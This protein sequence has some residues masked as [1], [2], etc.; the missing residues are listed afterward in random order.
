MPQKPTK[1]QP[2]SRGTGG[3]FSGSRD[4][5][6]GGKKGG[7]SKRSE[8]DKPKRSYSRDSEDR[9]S[10]GGYDR[11][12]A[13]KSFGDKKYGDRKPAGK[14]FGGDRKYGEKKEYGDRKPSGKSFG[15][16]KYGEKKEYGD[17]KPAGRGFGDKKFGDRKFGDKKEYGDRK[18]S[19]KSF[20]DRKY[21]DKK[22][23]GDRKPA[24]RGFGD[25]K[26]GDRK[27]G[28]RDR[29][30]GDRKFGPKKFGD[31]GQST[32][33]DRQK[34]WSR[35]EEPQRERRVAS[36]ETKG[37]LK[38][39]RSSYGSPS[40]NF[41]FGVHAVSQAL[42]NPQR[43][44]N[45]LLATEKGFAAIEES[46]NEARDEGLTVPEVTYVESEDIDRLTPRE[47]V[48]QDVLLDTAPLE[49]VFL[50][51]VLLHAKDDAFVVVL[52]QVTDP[53]NV[54]AILRSAAAF[55]AVAVIAQKLHAPEITGTLAKTASGAAEHVPLV[56]EVNLSRTLEQLKDAGFA[57]IGLDERGER[58]LAK[59]APKGKVAIVLGN[60]GDGLRRLV[61]ENCDFLAQLPTQG[62][63]ASLNVSNAAAIA[64]YELV[65][66]R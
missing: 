44:H 34:T 43:H 59:A 17:R 63:I 42:L 23:Y 58:T 3:K 39:G 20:G 24:G 1:F 61:A 8:G 55:G 50:Q 52:D 62:E 51:D 49:E 41:L 9:G 32:G 2:K 54:G 7:F 13:G 38:S 46:Y 65:R 28:D 64:L 60:E 30:S 31:R 29:D 6:S 45:R 15:D 36:D 33:F 37:K 4:G 16:R 10:K 22:E 47:A 66:A 26:F 19:G 25:K 40:P 48:H 12:P 57:C 11:K 35:S 56:R 53:H 5:A 21:G 18:P 27:F 14:G